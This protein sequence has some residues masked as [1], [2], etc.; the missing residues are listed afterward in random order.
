MAASQSVDKDSNETGWTIYLVLE[1]MNWGQRRGI[2]LRIN[3]VV[4]YDSSER[5]VLK[6]SPYRQAEWSSGC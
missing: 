1:L 4:V 6:I 3:L 2:L 5:Q